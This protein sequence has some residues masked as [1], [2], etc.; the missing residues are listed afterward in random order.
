M[1]WVEETGGIMRSRVQESR[2]DLFRE[3]DPAAR[4]YLAD[5][6][7]DGLIGFT[8]DA[9]VEFVQS[10]SIRSFLNDASPYDVARELTLQDFRFYS[11]IPALE[12]IV[13]L[14]QP[15]ACPNI[16]VMTA[17]FNHVRTWVIS[18]V[19]RQSSSTRARVEVLRKFIKVARLCRE[20]NNLNGYFA[21]V[22][23]LSATPV[24]RLTNT[25]DKL[26]NR[27]S[28]LFKG[29][30]GQLDPT[31]NMAKYRQLLTQ[32]KE[33]PPWVPFFPLL[34]KDVAFMHE[35]NKSRVDGL[36]N[37][38]K[39]RMLA[40]EIRRQ[41]LPPKSR[42]IS[43][44]MFPKKEGKAGSLKQAW[45]RFQS[46]RAVR[47]Y[48]ESVE[49]QVIFSQMSTPCSHSLHGRMVKVSPL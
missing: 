37:F 13:Y 36:V 6:Q 3:L 5:E 20:L 35:G 1:V 29:M 21:V 45:P 11:K 41:R 33:D 31:R 48:V 43:A 34:M 8:E 24:S 47:L 27:Y 16:E 17:W 32:V 18:E 25:W 12:Y 30:E 19:C 22:S 39:L 9:V 42:Y 49:V 44:S 40:R 28:E 46:A 38:E 4:Y 26:P 14:E 2:R 23:G 15:K 7:T 10:Y